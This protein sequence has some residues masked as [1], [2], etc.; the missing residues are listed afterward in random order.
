MIGLDSSLS[1]LDFPVSKAALQCGHGGF[2]LG[3][4]K[5]IV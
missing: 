3:L 1:E 2:V 4:A 5:E